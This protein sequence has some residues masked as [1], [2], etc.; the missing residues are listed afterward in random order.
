MSKTNVLCHG[1]SFPS[2]E[3]LLFRLDGIG[4]YTAA[5]I[6]TIVFNKR[7]IALDGNGKRVLLFQL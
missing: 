1:G 5:A 7:A 6:M 4:S 3:Q 2:D